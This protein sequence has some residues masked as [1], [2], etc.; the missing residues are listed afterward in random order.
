[1]I[2]DVHLLGQ[3]HRTTITTYKTQQPQLLMLVFHV[4]QPPNLHGIC[5]LLI[6]IVAVGIVQN[7]CIDPNILKP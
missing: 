3:K 5:D 2:K 4:C 7:S 1:M 6:I